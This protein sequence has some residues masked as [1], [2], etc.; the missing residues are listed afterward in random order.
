[1][2]DTIP[3]DMSTID[4]VIRLYICATMWHETVNEMTTFLKSILRMD[5]ERIPR[6]TA[7]QFQKVSFYYYYLIC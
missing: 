6:S 1:M 5:K 2:A 3:M 7:Q 4:N